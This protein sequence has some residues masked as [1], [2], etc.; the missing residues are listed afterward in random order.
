MISA[1]DRQT[2]QDTARRY[3]AT[4]VLLFGSASRPGDSRD[5]DIA[6]DGIADDDFYSFYGELLCALSKPVDVVDLS[7]KT[8]FTE[9]ILKEGVPLHA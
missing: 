8:K 7:R 1:H 6:V 5:I 4:R 9:L 2:I 3:K